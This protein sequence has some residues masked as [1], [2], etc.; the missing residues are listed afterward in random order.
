MLKLTKI[1]GSR[2]LGNNMGHTPTTWRVVGTD[3]TCER[4]PDGWSARHTDGKWAVRPYGW[5]RTELLAQLEK[6]LKN[7]SI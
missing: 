2:W 3:I 1:M 6:Q 7:K 4:G 5:S